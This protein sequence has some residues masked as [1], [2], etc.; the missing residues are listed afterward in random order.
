MN[1]K[2]KTNLEEYEFLSKVN[3]IINKNLNNS[4][5]SVHVLCREMG[6]S[7]SSLYRKIL[8]TTAM[9]I[10]GYITYYRLNLAMELI[11]KGEST[12]K[13]V[14]YQVGY[15]DC[16]YF[17]RAFKKEFNY[18]PSAYLFSKE[19]D[20]FI[21]TW[22]KAILAGRRNCSDNSAVEDRTLPH[23]IHHE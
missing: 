3:S 22:T 11:K 17:S 6:L 19:S 20:Q 8:A 2:V 21:S 16:H 14:A 15:N 12:I 7:R 5:F 4:E 18:P 1:S 10:V 23:L 9:T 13:Q